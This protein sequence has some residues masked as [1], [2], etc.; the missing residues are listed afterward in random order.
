MMVVPSSM[1]PFVQRT[2]LPLP[3]RLCDHRGCAPLERL[4]VVEIG[5]RFWPGSP[6]FWDNR[7]LSIRPLC[8][9]SG[10]SGPPG[11]PSPWPEGFCV[12]ACS[13]LLFKTLNA[14]WFI[15][16]LTGA[17]T[18]VCRTAGPLFATGATGVS[19]GRDSS[20]T[21]L[22]TRFLRSGEARVL[23]GVLDANPLEAA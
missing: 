22:A 1:Q 2:S 10:V 18:D 21:G 4:L 19:L 13:L 11:A 17:L 16:G 20:T 23:S 6:S 5:F 12:S 14:G 15:G 9:R 7:P 3:V 8:I